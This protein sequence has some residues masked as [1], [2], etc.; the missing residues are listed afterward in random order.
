MARCYFSRDIPNDAEWVNESKPIIEGKH[1]QVSQRSDGIFVEF[2]PH[3]VPLIEAAP[4]VPEEPPLLFDR[5]NEESTLPP[6]AQDI[7]LTS[8]D[9]DPIPF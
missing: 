5:H 4:P 8:E 2:L 7:D 6:S 1:V 3:S 9:D